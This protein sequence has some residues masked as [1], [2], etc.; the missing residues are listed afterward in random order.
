MSPSKKT[1][2]PPAPAP[3]A[4]RAAQA[5]AG[6][7]GIMAGVTLAPA[8]ATD[9]LPR[10]AGAATPGG[11]PADAGRDAQATR[12][13]RH[14]VASGIAFER[15]E[16]IYR[17]D[18]RKIVLQGPYIRQFLED[19]AF[20]QLKAAV[21]LEQD[22]GQHVGVRLV[23]PPTDQRRVLVYGMRRWKAALA[24]ELDRIPVRDYG[25]ISEDRA[26]ELQML[27]NEIRADPHP[28][29]TALG[30]FLLARQPE[31][32]QKR[33][34]QVFDK[35]KGYVSEMVRVGEAIA[36]LGA[37]ERQPLYTA[38]RVTVRAFQSVA[39]IRALAE[40]RAALL[41]L[42]ADAPVASPPDAAARPASSDADDASGPLPSL[43]SGG[44]ADDA[45][46]AAIGEGTV[47]PA[48]AATDQASRR[49]LVDEAVFHVRPLRNG[50]AFRCAGP[51]TTCGATARASP[52]SSGH[53]CWRSTSTCCTAPR[54]CTARCRGRGA[55]CRRASPTSWRARRSR[56]RASMRGSS[57]RGRGAPPR[58][59]GPPRH[60]PR[61]PATAR[62]DAGSAGRGA[63]VAPSGGPE[64]PGS[65][66]PHGG[67]VQRL[68]QRFGQ[69][70][71]GDGPGG[72]GCAER[73]ARRG[74]PA[75]P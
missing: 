60:R 53:G 41:A 66:R 9:P 4:S 23:G 39:Q 15:V 21:A 14:P 62:A 68:L 28:V 67:V 43:P 75:R 48:A 13:L 46:G 25:P 22:I 59:S 29:D 2:P 45:P 30:F 1:S 26:V 61:R 51:T 56:P 32:S 40:R 38:P 57:G 16:N 70:V 20:H 27:E 33:I 64:R 49:K 71:G 8:T 17:M 12:A 18:P 54:C 5:R 34:A 73:R 72:D 24:A 63:V 36:E 35:N 31:W 6:I 74:A 69:L 3:R 65:A 7:G 37:E 11:T 19:A 58:G 10:A 44:A 55:P 50:R 47:P 42:L 52:R